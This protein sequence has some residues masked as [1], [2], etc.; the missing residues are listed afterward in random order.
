M[1]RTV[2][3]SRMRGECPRA[4]PG[5]QGGA[6]VRRGGADTPPNDGGPGVTRAPEYR[7][8]ERREGAEPAYIMPPMSGMPPPTPAPSLS[9]ISATMASVVRMFF[10]IEA[11]FWSAERVTMAGS[12]MP[13]A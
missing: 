10:A 5:R 3:G 9:G 6:L 13:S 8:H 12:M 4:R 7:K 1:L 2:Q 11:A